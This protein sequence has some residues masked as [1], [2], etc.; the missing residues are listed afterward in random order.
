MT[1]AQFDKKPGLA[2]VIQTNTNQAVLLV[3]GVPLLENS[4]DATIESR[5]FSGVYKA[6]EVNGRW[7]LEARI[8]F[9]ALG[10]ILKQN[11]AV[12]VKPAE[13]IDI[14][15][16]LR[17]EVHGNLG[18]ATR[19]NYHANLR[20]FET[21]RGPVKY[22]FGGG[23]LWV[24]LPPGET[25]LTLSYSIAIEEGP[26]LTNSGCFLRKAGHVR[27]QYFWHP[28]FDF[29]SRADRADFEIEARIPKEYKLSTSIPQEE[30]VEGNERIV[31]GKS[32]QPTF[33]LTLVYDRDW[34]VVSQQI[35]GVHIELF[36][37]PDF[38]PSPTAVID[39]FRSVYSMLSSRFGVPKANYFGI[40]Q[41]RSR[42]GDGWLF[43]SNQ[44]V[45]AAGWP[46]SFSRKD[47]F[48]RAFLGHE[49]GH[50]WTNG[51]GAA[52][53]FLGEGWATYVESLVL[54]QAF[55]EETARQFWKKEVESYF[56]DYEGKASILEDENNSGVAYSKGAW[57]FRMLEEAVGTAAFQQAMKEYS[58][59]S[60]GEAAGWEVLAECF[61]KQGIQGFDARA[62]LE[63]WLKGRSAP[64]LAIE[65]QPHSVIFHQSGAPFILPVTLE[66][67]TSKG[68][69]RRSIWIRG[70]KEVL[71]FNDEVIKAEVDPE[72][73]LLLQR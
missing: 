21:P 57:I 38:R 66:A 20:Q 40:V 25:E 61:D 6:H 23:L 46:R 17:I 68:K 53:N 42:Q 69:E 50:L 36:V 52:A 1:Q 56:Q 33:A 16:R 13:R 49:I 65:T 29:N 24:D 58:T 47:G 12:Q 8:P 30:L 39:E 3:S 71:S 44:V 43:A 35:G 32:I 70:D 9:E 60:L 55:G 15:D 72:G 41:A 45:V 63:P 2:S 26:N 5:T 51:S 10:K 27:N 37:T 19:L 18:F 54:N 14:K 48:P 4:G 67:T 64:R 7:A 34:N 62:F 11:L 31:R 22:Q 59:R 28:F 73:L